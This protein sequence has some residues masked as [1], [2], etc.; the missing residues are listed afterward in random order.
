MLHRFTCFFVI[1]LS[2]S[3]VYCMDEENKKNFMEIERIRLQILLQETT[4]AEAEV[5]K[6]E[7][8]EAE[9]AR[10]QELAEAERVRKQEKESEAEKI[11]LL[12]L[13]PPDGGVLRCDFKPQAFA[14]ESIRER[15]QKLAEE[16]TFKLE[17]Q[18]G[19]NFR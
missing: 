9:R 17:V 6:Q 18:R 10:K 3:S 1:L 4:L 11:R 8:A 14:K 7:L 2:F 12:R 15:L 19:V 13:T 16:A 5:R